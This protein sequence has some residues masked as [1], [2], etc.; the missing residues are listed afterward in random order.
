MNACLI[1]NGNLRILYWL[2]WGL[3][4]ELKEKYGKKVKQTED[5]RG[6]NLP[7]GRYISYGKKYSRAYFIGRIL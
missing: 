5:M 3:R 6:V 7:N 1:L 2:R 4:N